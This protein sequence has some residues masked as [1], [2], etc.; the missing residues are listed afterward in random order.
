MWLVRKWLGWRWECS[1]GWK[2]VETTS[3]RRAT[4]LADSHLELFNWAWSVA[5][6]QD[7]AQRERRAVQMAMADQVEELADTLTGA[8][9]DLDD[10]VISPE[11]SWDWLRETAEWIREQ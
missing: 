4:L 11:A 6:E 3:R 5:V 1:C 9:I 7:E 8:Y 10:D 2:A